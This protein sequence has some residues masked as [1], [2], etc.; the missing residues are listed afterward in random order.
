LKAR[1]LHI[2]VAVGAP[3]K[4]KYSHIT[5]AAGAPLESEVLTY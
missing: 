3:L 5:V 4:A 1:Y 2:K